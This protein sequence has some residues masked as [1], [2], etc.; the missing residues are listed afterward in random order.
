MLN[1]YR[2]CIWACSQPVSREF[3]ILGLSFMTT[4]KIGQDK[5]FKELEDFDMNIKHKY[6]SKYLFMYLFTCQK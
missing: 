1:S 2:Q 6:H 4:E 3:S 5:S